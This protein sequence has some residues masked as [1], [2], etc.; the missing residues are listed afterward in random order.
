M[1]RRTFLQHSALVTAGL[2]SAASGL[3]TAC[4][5]PSAQSAAE[6]DTTAVASAASEPLFKISL[7]EWSFHKALFNPAALKLPWSEFGNKLKNDYA[8]LVAG[9]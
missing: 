2:S 1:Q 4:S 9:Q 3:L 7:A 5:N 6:G 8:F